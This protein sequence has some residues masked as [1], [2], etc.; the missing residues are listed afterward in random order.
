[1][2]HLGVT[3]DSTVPR[4]TATFYQQKRCHHCTK[5]WC[6]KRHRIWRIKSQH[7]RHN[8]WLLW[9]CRRNQRWSLY[10]ERNGVHCEVSSMHLHTCQALSRLRKCVRRGTH[11]KWSHRFVWSPEHQELPSGTGYQHSWTF[12]GQHGTTTT[13]HTDLPAEHTART[14]SKVPPVVPTRSAR[15][16]PQRQLVVDVLWQRTHPAKDS[17]CQGRPTTS[18]IKTNICKKNS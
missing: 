13:V 12:A 7:V 14:A 15:R 4:A 11:P 16:K 5:T 3:E 1:M 10:N 6:E 8:P 2:W 18:K 9:I 17:K